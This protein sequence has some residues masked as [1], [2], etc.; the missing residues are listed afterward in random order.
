MHVLPQGLQIFELLLAD[1]AGLQMLMEAGAFAL[2]HRLG[3]CTLMR[4]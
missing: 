2:L 3:D 1:G 4:R